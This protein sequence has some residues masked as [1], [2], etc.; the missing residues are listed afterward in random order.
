[1]PPA[2]ACVL[3]DDGEYRDW[4]YWRL[5][6]TP[7]SISYAEAKRRV[8]ETAREAV[9]KR[10]AADVPLGAFLSGG[11]DSTIVVGLMSELTA[12]PVLTFS[13]GFADDPTYDETRYARLAA[14]RFGTRHTEFVVEADA[15]ALLDELVEAYDEPFGDSS[16][17]P[18]H[19]VSGLTRQHVIALTQIH[20]VFH[21]TFRYGMRA[22]VGPVR[23]VV[24]SLE[25][26]RE[27]PCPPLV[28]GGPADAVAPTGLGETEGALLNFEDETYSLL[29]H[30]RLVPVHRALL[31]AEPWLIGTCQP[32]V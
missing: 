4:R 12:E 2:T 11:V 14:E 6:F 21:D 26:L 28:S 20:D 18:T 31:V 3:E 30:G 24:E 15:L 7:R 22:V 32:S 27:E 25:S 9:R 17:I 13:L 5:D 16:A 29:V 1:M 23:A 10:L 8:R 19:I